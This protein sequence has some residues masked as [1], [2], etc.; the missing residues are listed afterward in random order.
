[1]HYFNFTDEPLLREFWVNIYT[2]D[3]EAVK[4]EALQMRGYGGVTWTFSPIAPGT[5]MVY[6]YSHPITG[7][8]FIMALLGH[9]HSHGRRFT[10]SIT[11]NGSTTPEKLYET[12]DYNEPI[13]FHYNTIVDNPAFADGSAGAVSGVLEVHNGDVLN[14]ECHV[15]ND[16]EVPLRYTNEVKTG[17]MCNL[18]GHSVGI[19][20]W[21]VNM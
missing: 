8:G 14:W 21:D 20:K 13:L 16:G 18:W 17:E 11:R 10:A 4:R 5:D 6:S 2:I 19:P 12:F 9:Y 15:I 3:A 1:M 7:D